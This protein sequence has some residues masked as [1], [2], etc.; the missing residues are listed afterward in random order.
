MH[1]REIEESPLEASTSSNFIESTAIDQNSSI[2]P[3]TA[4]RTTFVKK[5]TGQA[6]EE[7]ISKYLQT[8]TEMMP[9]G[10]RMICYSS[11]RSF[12]Q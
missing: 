4:L 12:V 9:R 6:I 1:L 3:S 7:N 10:L 8:A 2:T 5:R 11:N